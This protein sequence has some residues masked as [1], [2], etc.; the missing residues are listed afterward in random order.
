MNEQ[1][2]AQA[3]RDALLQAVR[4]LRERLGSVAAEHAADRAQL[5][6]VYERMQHIEEDIEARSLQTQRLELVG[7]LVNEV[8]HD[9]NNYLTIIHGQCEFLQSEC[10]G[11]PSAMRRLRMLERAA[12]EA[13][14][15]VA[16]ILDFSRHGANEPERVP[17][18]QVVQRAVDTLRQLL[19]RGI[20][21]SCTLAE[22]DCAVDCEP[23]HL[24]QVLM[25][26]GVNA[27]DA[28]QGS[29]ELRIELTRE[30]LRRQRNGF[31]QPVVPGAYAC[32]RCT[33]SGCG[34]DH[35]VMG[36]IF[37]PFYTTKG[38]GA[39]TGVG[40]ATVRRIMRQHAGYVQ[41]ESEPGR[42]TTFALYLPLP[43]APEAADPA[44]APSPAAPRQGSILLGEDV[45]RIRDLMDAS[46]LAA[47]FGLE[48]VA[49]GAAALQRLQQGPA[50][51][52]LLVDVVMPEM[53]GCQ[54]VAQLPHARPKVLFISGYQSC[55]AVLQARKLGH[56]LLQKPFRLE[57]LVATVQH[58]LAEAN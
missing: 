10:S 31:P 49:G 13:T 46:L 33:D 1:E 20:R 23:G 44:P 28:M 17:L 36:R 39:G 29:G 43:K 38:D 24:L 32:L 53:D 25:N 18:Q 22:P 55:P 9:F 6:A 54:L 40:L 41:V 56:P 48:S 45:R 42:G 52:L 58:T 7:A 30:E 57:H 50:F 14:E 5:A 21:V 35:A 19:P 2:A 3:G 47:G 8:A 15:L 12:A 16:K 51:D 27:R 4:R 34:M 26:L 11:M 37:E